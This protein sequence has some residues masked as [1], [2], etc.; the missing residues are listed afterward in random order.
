MPEHVVRLVADA[1]NEN[2]KSVK[3]SQILVI[4]IAY[5]RD[6]DDVR[7]SPALDIIRLLAAQG[8]EVDYNDP[9]VPEVSEDLE[10]PMQSINGVPE[11][12][13]EYDCVVV[14]TD[15]TNYDWPAIIDASSLLID[16]RNV[17]EGRDD[18]HVVRL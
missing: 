1:L 18:A 7:E 6:I 17:T 12:C 8:A 14:C 3:G 15:H 10:A 13:S 11:V 16:T 4:G 2:S 9:Y 5:K